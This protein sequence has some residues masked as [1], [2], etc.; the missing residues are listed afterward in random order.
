MSSRTLLALVTC[1]F[2]LVVA[3]SA[4]AQVSHT[5]IIVDPT[6]EGICEPADTTG[7]ELYSMKMTQGGLDLTDWHWFKRGESN[8]GLWMS[9]LSYSL[10]P[11]NHT[12]PVSVRDRFYII[13]T[14]P[15][16][17]GR[18]D[19]VAL[20]SSD[21]STPNH[22]AMTFQVVGETINPAHDLHAGTGLVL[23]GSGSPV[24][25][26]LGAGERM[27]PAPA[28]SAI[29]LVF[30]ALID[31][32]PALYAPGPGCGFGMALPHQARP[33]QGLVIGYN[34][35]RQPDLGSVP[36][37]TSWTSEHWLDFIPY[38][39]E[40]GDLAGFQDLNTTPQD[41]NEFLFYSD[42]GLD[43]APR[44]SGRPAP[45]RACADSHWYVI[46][47][48]VDGDY[49][50]FDETTVLARVPLGFDPR[51][52][53]GGLDLTGDG[54]PEFFSPQAFMGL[55]GLGLTVEGRPVLSAPLLGCTASNPLSAAGQVELRGGTSGLEL[56]VGLEP[57]EVAGYDVYRLG[58]SGR[59]RVNG[60]LIPAVG[61]EGG[62]HR[63]ATEDRRAV[64]GR[65]EI[66]VVFNDGR[67]N[68]VR[69]PYVFRAR[70]ERTS[71]RRG[72]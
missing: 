11:G 35:Y 66:E 45:Q 50:D 38:V 26:D 3:G 34:I 6:P 68:E 14:R 58:A 30:G 51:Q 46:Q 63:L 71:R 12:V 17:D 36:E 33:D 48:V 52:L 54:E 57:A 41:G 2:V 28:S 21:S 72:R 4:V 9:G 7:A 24:S 32:Q 42:S 53:D 69:G 59:S 31:Y 64:T 20:D 15:G 16:T 43:E 47:P 61:V 13:I 37:P 55:P 19:A 10:N 49:F 5:G 18:G 65:Y 25:I 70:E 8:A 67:E 62:V 22:G 39:D 56:V 23:D 29:D 1:C 60:G 27:F 44:P 40:P